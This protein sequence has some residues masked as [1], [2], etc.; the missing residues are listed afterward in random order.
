[1]PFHQMRRLCLS[2]IKPL[3]QGIRYKETELLESN[4]AFMWFLIPN[5]RYSHSTQGDEENLARS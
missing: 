3:T 1:M 5:H 2:K 4:S